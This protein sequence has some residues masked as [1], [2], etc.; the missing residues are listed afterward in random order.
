MSIIISSHLRLFYFYKL[1]FIIQ[2]EV[3][4][5][6]IPLVKGSLQLEK[7]TKVE[8]IEKHHQSGRLVTFWAVY[9]TSRSLMS[10]TNPIS[11]Q[12]EVILYEYKY[13]Q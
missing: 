11:C 13:H 12:F 3:F 5:I 8:D 6:T 2:N 1:D 9:Y 7:T 10:Y 4:V